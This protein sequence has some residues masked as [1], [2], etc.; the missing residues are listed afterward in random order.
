MAT[1]MLHAGTHDATYVVQ[2]TVIGLHNVFCGQG[3]QVTYVSTSPCRYKCKQSSST[4]YYAMQY[5]KA[6]ACADKFDIDCV[7]WV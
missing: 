7:T 6:K 5:A 3:S 4:Y 2:L 1:Y